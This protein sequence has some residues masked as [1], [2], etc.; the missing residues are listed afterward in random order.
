MVHWL[1][2]VLIDLAPNQAKLSH[3][4]QNHLAANHIP[5]DSLIKTQKTLCDRLT[6]IT[7]YIVK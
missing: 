1:I 5:F 2:Q 7:K 3:E 4:A 6:S